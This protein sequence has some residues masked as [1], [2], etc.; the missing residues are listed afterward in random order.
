MVVNGATVCIPR[1]FGIH[2]AESNYSLLAAD[3]RLACMALVRRKF[4]DQSVVTAAARSALSDVS[5]G[6]NQLRAE[7][8]ESNRE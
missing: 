2:D 6:G 8:F 3:T 1:D 5:N 4:I 7:G